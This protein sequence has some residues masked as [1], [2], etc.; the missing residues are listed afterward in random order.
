MHRLLGLPAFADVGGD[1]AQRVNAAIRTAQRQ[2]DG[3]EGVFAQPIGAAVDFLFFHPLAALDH[4]QIIDSQL[5]DGG[6]IKKSAVALADH[7]RKG[8]PK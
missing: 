7:G 6:G 2:F 3:Q 8:L 1:A 4:P 5:G